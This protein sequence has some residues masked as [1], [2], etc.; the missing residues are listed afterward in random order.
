[1][2]CPFTAKKY[3]DN[4]RSYLSP[5]NSLVLLVFELAAHPTPDSKLKNV[6]RWCKQLPPSPGQ[7]YRVVLVGTYPDALSGAG[8]DKTGA[9]DLTRWWTPELRGKLA[10]AF[11][12]VSFHHTPFAVAVR[13]KT[14]AGAGSVSGG[15]TPHPA[16][17]AA[18]NDLAQRVL[19]GEDEDE[20]GVV[21][22]LALDAKSASSV[23]SGA[24]SNRSSLM[25]G[26]GARGSLMMADEKAKDDDGKPQQE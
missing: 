19:K 9:A 4:V 11:S 26:M 16:F 15:V 20:G 22:A 2:L 14:V 12:H 7:K 25:M 8:E 18:L 13:P 24:G 10:Q 5:S 23:A 17:A 3:M 6:Q 1:M 21:P